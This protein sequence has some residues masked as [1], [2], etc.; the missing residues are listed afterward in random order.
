MGVTLAKRK[1]ST[2]SSSCYSLLSKLLKLPPPSQQPRHFH[3]ALLAE[4][5]NSNSFASIQHAFTLL[6]VAH[7]T[8]VSLK[9]KWSLFLC[10]VWH[11]HTRTQHVL[12]N[13]YCLIIW[14]NYFSVA[15]GVRG[16]RRYR[17]QAKLKSNCQLQLLVMSR[18]TLVLPNM[19]V[20]VPTYCHWNWLSTLGINAGSPKVLNQ[21]WQQRITGSLQTKL[22]KIKC[23]CIKELFIP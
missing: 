8:A 22:D 17:P 12:L 9:G 13:T 11:Q 4:H 3:G 2:N 5:F 16:Q 19:P 23:F 18:I 1:H 20:A 14:C 7:S 6:K 15:Y 10:Q 21:G